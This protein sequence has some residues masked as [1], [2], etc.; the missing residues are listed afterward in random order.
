MVSPYLQEVIP[1][2]EDVLFNLIGRLYCDLR[3][4]GLRI[5]QLQEQVK[6]MQSKPEPPPDEKDLER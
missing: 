2:N 6:A 3:A 4:A 5:Q 1:V